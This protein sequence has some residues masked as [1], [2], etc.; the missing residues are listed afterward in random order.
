MRRPFSLTTV[1][2][3]SESIS[4]CVC[5][6]V[7][8][9]QAQE[10]AARERQERELNDSTALSE[11]RHMVTSDLLTERPEAAERPA[12]P[13]QGRR[14]LTDRWK[15]MTSEQHSAILR[16]QE[17]QRLEREVIEKRLTMVSHPASIS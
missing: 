10:R 15:G 6:C 4:T 2:M 13:G 5:V 17:Q 14:V 3:C 7:R 1:Q 16:E 11:I 8:S 12:W 9:S